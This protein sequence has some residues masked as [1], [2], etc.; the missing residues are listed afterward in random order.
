MSGQIWGEKNHFGTE[1]V[2]YLVLVF[3]VLQIV[4]LF[5]SQT[6][7]I[8]PVYWHVNLAFE[9][10]NE[11]IFLSHRTWSNS[12]AT[13]WKSGPS[14]SAAAGGLATRPA[15]L[16]LHLH[17]YTFYFVYYTYTTTRDNFFFPNKTSTTFS[18]K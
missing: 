18:Q 15:Y 16:I 3:F 2:A 14:S 8:A 10:S 11:Y 1:G 5:A 17:S 6:R 9:T 13:D 4:G 7:L 12:N